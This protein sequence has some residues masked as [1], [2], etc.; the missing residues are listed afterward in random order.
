MSWEECVSGGLEMFE[1][2][3]IK[4]IVQ[5]RSQSV[6]D[7]AFISNRTAELRNTIRCID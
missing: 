7:K 6:Y 2:E 4:M 5:G 1:N 3:R